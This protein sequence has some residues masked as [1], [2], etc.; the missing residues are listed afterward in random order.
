MAMYLFRV[1][2]NCCLSFSNL[3]QANW[4]PN[5][6]AASEK[7]RTLHM[8]STHNN[9][10]AKT[11]VVLLTHST[12]SLREQAIGIFCI[13]S[14]EL[15]CFCVVLEIMKTEP[16]KL[17]ELDDSETSPTS[18]MAQQ[19]WI[20]PPV[21]ELQEIRSCLILM[22]GRSPGGGNR[23]PFQFSGMANFIDREPG[24]LQS[25]ELQKS[26]ISLSTHRQGCLLSPSPDN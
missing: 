20:P 18:P 16:C 17:P 22:S 12:L 3:M 11:E 6:Q 7:V 25:K 1:L 13:S 23:K 19:S 2:E 10:E 21:K 4:E 9:G 8:E 5:L 14:E 26:W 24:G 15:L